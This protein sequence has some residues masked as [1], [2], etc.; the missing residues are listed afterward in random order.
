MT[1]GLAG[2]ATVSIVTWLAIAS[3]HAADLTQASIAGTYEILICE[4]SCQPNADNNVWVKGRVVLFPD[5]MKTDDVARFDTQFVHG[6]PLNACFALEKLQEHLYWGYAGIE[7]T[8]LTVWSV[9]DAALQF[10]LFHSPDAGY[11]VTVQPTSTG[12]DATGKSWGAGVAAPDWQGDD[13]VVMRRIGAAD[14]SQ[15]NPGS[16]GK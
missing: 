1:F 15:C 10:S 3:A 6:E 11:Q 2:S 14:M 7:E 4:D 12:F 9:Q 8:G 5:E 13:K 16:I